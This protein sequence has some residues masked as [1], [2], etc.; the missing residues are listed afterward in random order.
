MNKEKRNPYQLADST[1]T[2]GQTSGGSQCKADRVQTIDL[3]QK[4]PPIVYRDGRRRQWQSKQ[5]LHERR[6][7]R[8]RIV[9]RWNLT[10]RRRWQGGG[11]M[12]EKTALT[13]DGA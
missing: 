2:G 8:R 11:E 10:R 1:G 6:W 5:T 9:S 13:E 7:C 3:E 4:R 12:W